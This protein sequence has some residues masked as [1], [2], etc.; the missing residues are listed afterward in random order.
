MDQTFTAGSDTGIRGGEGIL[1]AVLGQEWGH[2]GPRTLFPLTWL[3]FRFGPWDLTV[4][5]GAKTV[6]LGLVRLGGG[7]T[8]HVQMLGSHCPG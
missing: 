3:M 6:G 1:T 2:M 8:R 7:G 5:L 4:Y